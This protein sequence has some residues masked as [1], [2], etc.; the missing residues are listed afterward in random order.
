MSSPTAQSRRRV[1]VIGAGAAGW[2]AAIFSATAGAETTLVER[3]R[4]G[5]RKILISGG[6]R[7]NVLPMRVDE[8]RYVTDSSPNLLRKML[9]SWPL[10]EQIAFFERELHLPLAEEPESS[11][12]FPR[13]NKARDVRDGLLAYAARAGATLRMNT[14]VT[15]FAPVDGRWRVEFDADAP[16]DADAVIVATGGLSVPNTGSQG[17]G[18]RELAK[19]GHEIHPVYA[20]LTPVTATDSPFADLSGVSLRLTLSARDEA[21]GRA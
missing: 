4:D 19:L 18:L 5:G 10:A 3:T 14:V 7:C 12:L 13:S 15:G 2:M 1:V 9:R 16:M 17:L 6:G 20:A 21:A 8:A 11:K